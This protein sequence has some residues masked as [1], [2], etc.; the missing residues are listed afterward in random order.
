MKRH[1]KW[2]LPNE[3]GQLTTDKRDYLIDLFC[4]CIVLWLWFSCSIVPSFCRSIVLHIIL[5]LYQS[6]VLPFYHPP[7]TL[8]PPYPAPTYPT[9][10]PPLVSDPPSLFQLSTLHPS[11]QPDQVATFARRPA[12]ELTYLRAASPAPKSH[13]RNTNTAN[14]AVPSTGQGSSRP[15]GAVTKS[16]ASPLLDAPR[17]IGVQQWVVVHSAHGPSLPTSQSSRALGA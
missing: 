8:H 2:W 10:P 15:A 5:P 3:T 4:G 12:Y 9:P 16:H 6:I 7:S 17:P 1:K 14:Q 13:A 11:L